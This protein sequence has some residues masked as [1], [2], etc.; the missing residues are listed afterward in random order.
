FDAQESKSSLAVKFFDFASGLRFHGHAKIILDNAHQDPTFLSEA[1]GAEIFRSADVPVGKVTFARVELN[2]R[3]LGLYVV[4]QAINREFLA[5]HFA[6]TKGNL[7]EGDHCDITEKLEQD[8]GE[9]S[10]DQ[11]DLKKLAAAA[12]EPDRGQRWKK[13]AAVLDLD[14]FLS[15]LAGE[16]LTWHHNGYSMGRNN[17]RIYHDPAAGQMVFIPHSLD[18]LFTKPTGPLLPQWKGLLAKAVL[19]TPEGQQRDRERL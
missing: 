5:E 15:L 18:Q 7:Y 2:G 19:D 9:S 17:Y 13:L 12:R 1:L 8:S 16:V 14:R 4:A 10:P 11:A 6:K 3:D